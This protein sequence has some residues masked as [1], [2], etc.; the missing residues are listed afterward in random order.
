MKNLTHDN[1]FPGQDM[2]LEPPKYGAEV[3]G[4]DVIYGQMY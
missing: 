2:N 1:Q 4:N 3:L